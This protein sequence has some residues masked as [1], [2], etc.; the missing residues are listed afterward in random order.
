MLL[1]AAVVLAVV[2]AVPIAD[3]VLRDGGDAADAAAA[4]AAS[5]PTTMSLYMVVD[6]RA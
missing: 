6:L 2:A 1:P 5:N 4:E 3:L